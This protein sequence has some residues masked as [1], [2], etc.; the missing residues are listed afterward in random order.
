MVLPPLCDDLGCNLAQERQSRK[1]LV[2]AS[3]APGRRRA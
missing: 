1:G 3:I 2:G